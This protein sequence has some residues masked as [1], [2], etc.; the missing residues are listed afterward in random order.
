LTQKEQHF[1]PCTTL[2]KVIIGFVG[3]NQPTS[4]LPFNPCVEV[5]W[6]LDKEFWGYGFATEAGDS[7]LEYAFKNLK[8]NEVVAF[9]AVS[10]EKSKAVMKRL[11]MKNS[12]ENFNHLERFS[13]N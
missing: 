10:N 2:K 4:E 6:R 9:T 12:N 7:A 11:G 5:G 1:K 3:L 8:L 13:T